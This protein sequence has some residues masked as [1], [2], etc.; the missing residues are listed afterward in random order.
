MAFVTDGVID[1]HMATLGI[2]KVAL[3]SERGDPRSYSFIWR[4][5]SKM[6]YPRYDGIVFQSDAARKC[7]GKRV[8]SRSIVIPNASFLKDESITSYSGGTKD[9]IVSAGRFVP[10]KRFKDLIEAFAIVAEKLPNYELVIYGDGPLRSELNALIGSLGLSGKVAL[11]GYINNVATLFLESKAFVL[12]SSSEG[13]PNVLL[14]AMS[15]GMPVIS[16]DYGPGGIEAL[17]EN[18]VNGLVVPVGDLEKLADAILF[19]LTDRDAAM[20]M[21]NEALR[22]KDQ[23]DPRV[24]GKKWVEY[25]QRFI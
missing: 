18:G 6:I 20:T 15:I 21:G 7:F 23:F 5:L 2:R 8:K 4:L 12:S 13:M 19:M 10:E 3:A 9:Q 11:P 16:T 14:E 25:L 24:V 17:I 1:A 22:I